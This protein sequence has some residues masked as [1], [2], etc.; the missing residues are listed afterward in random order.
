MAE[1]NI[2]DW[3]QGLIN[4]DDDVNGRKNGLLR[5]ENVELDQNGALVLTGGTVRLDGVYS[6]NLHS[7][8]SKLL[9]SGTPESPQYR[10]AADTSGGVYR[11]SG[12]N[13]T[14]ASGGSTTRA[15]FGSL[16]EYAIICSGS[17]R[18]RDD[19]TTA[20][21]LGQGTSGNPA[22]VLDG[23]GI[24]TG[25]YDYIQ[26]CVFVNSGGGYQAR[27]APSAVQT[28]T[29]SSNQVKVTPSNVSGAQNE[30]WIFRRGVNLPTFYRIK[31]ITSGYTT[32]FDDNMSDQDAL[33]Q[34][35]IANLNALPI[36]ST[37]LPDDILEIVGP[38]NQRL[39]LFTAKTLHITEVNSPESYNPNQ[40]INFMGAPQTAEVF[41]WARKLG[42]NVVLV[43]TT[44]E[45]YRVTGTFIE[46]ADGTLDVTIRPLGVDAP[47]IGID[48]D[49]YLNNVAY[50]SAYGWV[51]CDQYGGITPLC[52]PNVDVNYYGKTRYGINGVPIYLVSPNKDYRYSCAIIR[53]KL[54]VA[55][56]EITGG[57]PSHR[58]DVYDFTR[59]YW[60]SIRYVSDAAPIVLRKQEDHTVIGF[61]ADDKYVKRLDDQFT[62]TFGNSSP[63]N[64]TVIIRTPFYD[65]DLP[66]NRKDAATLKFKI[67]T[68]GVNCAIGLYTDGNGSSG[69]SLGNISSSGMSEQIIDI[70]TAGFTPNIFK[71]FL[72]T[73]QCSSTVFRLSDIS[74]V[75]QSRP[76]QT[77]FFRVPISN[78]G[79]ASKKRVRTWPFLIDIVANGNTVTFT[80]TVDGVAQA[81]TNFVVASGITKRTQFHFFKT[82]I[83]GT[84]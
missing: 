16:F 8:F 62:F 22:V 71:S 42:Q 35:I 57:S 80:P 1:Y 37:N 78:F 52:P 4:S 81:A 20:T 46:Q 44:Q 77:T 23:A 43:G 6:N 83:F 19:G 56:P 21:N 36:D 50:M 75:Y 59:K 48:A 31:R 67:D 55:V 41:C 15:A 84:D 47:P 34:G 39:L 24:L 76:E 45:I 64:Q 70:N 10:Y 82:D 51:M 63:V 28:I 65:C 30:V 13:A 12:S 68:G 5:M 27:T 53:N 54:F 58:V 32:P 3:S 49:I 26:I 60:R 11:S 2:R 69:T 74:L 14:I 7:L 9:G 17:V 29:T 79:I 33:D 61:F 18:I 40:S 25:T 72:L 73:I 66:R 38:L